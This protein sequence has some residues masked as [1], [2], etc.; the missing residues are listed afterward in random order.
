MPLGH[1]GE[2]WPVKKGA[3]LFPVL[4]IHVAELPHVP[5]FLEGAEYWSLFIEPHQ[6]EQA[7]D[8]G[9]L[10]VRRYPHI[11][12]LEPLRPSTDTM[13]ARLALRF[14]QVVDFPSSCALE[15]ALRS[16]PALLST[17]REQSDDL[18]DLFPCHD[19]IKLG[20]YPLLVHGTTFLQ[21]LHPDFQIQLDTTELYSYADSGVG[22]VYGG[23]TA[24]IWESM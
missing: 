12:G 4:S 13:P 10:V 9:S 21:S 5:D 7:T 2:T 19:G 14:R 22:Y 24:A 23:L 17:Y 11:S 15:Q 3:P 6:F 20:G 1:A 18:E 16:N 8:D